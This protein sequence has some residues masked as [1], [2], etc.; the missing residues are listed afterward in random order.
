LGGGLDTLGGKV[1]TLNNGAKELNTT[2]AGM[3]SYLNYLVDRV[4][5]KNHKAVD[6]EAA[7]FRP[8]EF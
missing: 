6:Q 7:L 3:N 5:C 1:K 2:V 8:S 4:R